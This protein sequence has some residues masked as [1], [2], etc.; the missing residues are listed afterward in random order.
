MHPKKDVLKCSEPQKF[1]SNF[2]GSSWKVSS[3]LRR[4]II[5]IYPN[6]SNL[7]IF[8][9]FVWFVKICEISAPIGALN[10]LV[11]CGENQRSLFAKRGKVNHTNLS[12]SFKYFYLLFDLVWFVKI[13]EIS[14]PIGALYSL[15]ACGDKSFKSIQIFQI[16]LSLVDLFDLWRFV[17]FLRE[18][19][20]IF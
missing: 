17:R 3:R 7:F 16:F 13:C 6:L 9:W 1:L 15:V 2:W 18:A 20:S 5:Q 8:S 19:H 11:A 12:K 14:A 10:I 4:E